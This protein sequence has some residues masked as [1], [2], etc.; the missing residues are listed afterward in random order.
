MRSRSIKRTQQQPA[1]TNN[2]KKKRKEKEERGRGFITCPRELVSCRA[3]AGYP[4]KARKNRL[5]RLGNHL[6]HMQDSRYSYP[7]AEAAIS[8]RFVITYAHELQVLPPASQAI[9]CSRI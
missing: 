5:T 2:N 1:I 6:E 3:N 9:T 4:A 8:F 7:L